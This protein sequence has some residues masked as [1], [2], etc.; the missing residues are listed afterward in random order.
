MIARLAEYDSETLVAA[1]GQDQ[2]QEA[3]ITRMKIQ[4]NCITKE[5]NWTIDTY[6]IIGLIYCHKGDS[7]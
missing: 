7:L 2:L 6:L 1:H 3:L 4:I 5:P